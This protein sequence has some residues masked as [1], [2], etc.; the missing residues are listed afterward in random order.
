[1]KV[2]LLTNNL[3]LVKPLI[4]WMMIEK[5][6]QVIVCETKMN[7]VLVK[8]YYP[9]FIISYNYRFIIEKDIVDMYINKIVNLHISFLPYN[10]GAHPNVWSFLDKTPNGV[11]IHYIDAGLDTG[12]VL[13]QKEMAFPVE[14][15]TLE[16]SYNALHSEIQKL[17][18]DN[19]EKI[20]TGTIIPKKQSGFSTFHK[21]SQF[22]SLKEKLG[23]DVFTIP[24]K[25]LINRYEGIIGENKK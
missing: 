25:T 11:S 16:S 9:D 12:D 3:Q 6:D 20:K 15:S 17:F 19:W 7:Q 13:V 5:A 24:I 4:E 21:Q 1:M 18:I 14:T 2:L 22:N 8:K 10:R 23:N